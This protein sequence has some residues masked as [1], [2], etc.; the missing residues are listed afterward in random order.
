LLLLGVLLG[1]SRHYIFL[2]KKHFKGFIMKKGLLLPIYCLFLLF[3]VACSTKATYIALP[4]SVNVE[5]TSLFSVGEI[6]DSSKFQF[7][8]GETDTLV[9]TDAMSE[10][11][12]KALKGK[13]ALGDG[14][15]II[16]V[17]IV[18]YAPGNAF[19]RW[20]LPGAGETLLKVVAHIVSQEGVAAARLPVERSIA[21]GGG[22]TVGAWEY[23]FTE[24]AETIVE[25]LTDMEKRTGEKK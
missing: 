9:L 25:Y 2:Q 19:M 20:L 11:L 3:V 4:D 21:A 6:T 18:D 8:Q 23:I 10:A 1:L 14:Q 13:G 5:P 17:D 7:P 24:V 15:W 12:E 22:Y 16:N